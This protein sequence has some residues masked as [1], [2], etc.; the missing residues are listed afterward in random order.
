VNI[1]KLPELLRKPSL[2]KMRS[3]RMVS[4]LGQRA[5]CRRGLIHPRSWTPS[6]SLQH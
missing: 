3:I 1:G 2:A 6:L 4:G 5:R